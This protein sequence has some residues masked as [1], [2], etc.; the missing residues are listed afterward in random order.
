[1]T[2]DHTGTGA[3]H[4]CCATDVRLDGLGLDRSEH[5]QIQHSI[6]GPLLL[7]LHQLFLLRRRGGNYQLG[8][9]L[10]VHPGRFAEIVQHVLAFDTHCGL[11]GGR[12]WVVNTR[13]NYLAVS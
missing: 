8:D 6:L 3:Q 4:G 11:V 12:L 5:S 10:V 13:M 1:V 2:I 9:P 7:E